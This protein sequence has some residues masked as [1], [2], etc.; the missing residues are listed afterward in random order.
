MNEQIE[1]YRNEFN[2]LKKEF[3]EWMEEEHEKGH[4]SYRYIQIR[5]E[6]M[7]ELLDLMGMSLSTPASPP[8]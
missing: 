8:R 2:R 3:D 6:R 4:P 1:Q 5:L 7:N